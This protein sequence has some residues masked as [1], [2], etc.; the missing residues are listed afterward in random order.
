MNYSLNRGLLFRRIKD[1]P[2]IWYL[3]R[4][5]TERYFRQRV[6]PP[7]PLAENIFSAIY[8][9]N[10]WNDTE[11]ISGP[12]SALKH[13]RVLIEKLPAFL[14]QYHINSMLDAPCGDFN[15]M[16]DVDKLGVRYI[17]GDIVQELIDINN[18]RFGTDQI[19]FQKINIISDPL[20]DVDL[21]LVRD[22]LIHFNDESIQLFVKNL[23]ASNIRYLLT[24]NF[25]L[26]KHNYDITMGNFRFINLKR[27]P[28]HFPPEMDI[29]WED[30]TECYGQCPDKSLFLWRVED[31]RN[32]RAKE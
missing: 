5:Y 8:E 29:L 24:T 15:W 20:P 4:L 17:G 31:I 27:K 2:G 13:T 1:L 7:T 30:S 18:Q 10:Y 12:G 23:M 32:G 21:M 26:T 19:S 14:Q 11:S 25:P 6:K 28:Y 3:F 16:Q 9:N 22:C